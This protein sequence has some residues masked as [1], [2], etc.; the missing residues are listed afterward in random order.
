MTKVYA[1]SPNFIGTFYKNVAKNYNILATLYRIQNSPESFQKLRL[2]PQEATT[3]VVHM[4][5][6]PVDNKF[7]YHTQDSCSYSSDI[8]KRKC[9]AT[10]VWWS[11]LAL[12]SQFSQS[13]Q[14]IWYLNDT[15]CLHTYTT[16]IF[17]RVWPL[18]DQHV[19]LRYG[20]SAY[21]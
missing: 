11:K 20:C 16:C 10:D 1:K 12:V 21:S 4:F 5:P 3:L 9:S 17:I 6:Q 7:D 19:T 13:V 18:Y 15:L 2:L 14:F 8:R